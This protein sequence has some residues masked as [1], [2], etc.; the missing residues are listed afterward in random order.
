MSVR[1]IQK[2]TVSLRPESLSKDEETS[3]LTF[4]TD[5]YSF[6]NK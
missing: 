3:R 5:G 1:K 4:Y 2:R 6:F